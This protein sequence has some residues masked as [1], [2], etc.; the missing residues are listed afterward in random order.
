LKLGFLEPK[1]KSKASNTSQRKRYFSQ[2]QP[3]PSS[4]FSQ[5]VAEIQFLRD[6]LSVVAPNNVQPMQDIQLNDEQRIVAFAPPDVP[7]SIRAGAG[8]GKTHAMVQ[9]ARH[10]VT[11]CDIKPEEI[12]MITFSNKAAKEL[13]DRIASAF[14]NLGSSDNYLRQPTIKT[15]HGLAFAWVRM[16]WKACGLGKSLTIMDKKS[17]NKALMKRAISA[18]LDSLRLEK[19]KIMLWKSND[20]QSEE[21]TWNDVLDYVRLKYAKEYNEA[22]V[23]ADKEVEEKLPKKNKSGS[24]KSAALSHDENNEQALKSEMKAA[25]MLCMRKNCYLALL[26]LNKGKDATC[27]LER[28]WTGKSDQCTM[29]VNLIQQARLGG[30]S[31]DEYLEQDACVLKLYNQLQRETGQ[32]DFDNLLV[33][34]TEKVLGHETLSRRFN[35]M[36]SHVVVD[37]YQDNSDDQAKM[38]S[39]IVR[40]GSLTVVGDDDQ[41]SKSIISSL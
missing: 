41:C 32:L 1:A 19:C 14:S 3:D 22:C 34:F 8:S 33:V 24:K 15:F 28:R 10:L 26:R 40:N 2:E 16:H 18:Y 30:H 39:T 20:E 35:G 37:E 25:R 29:Y 12:L 31:F 5:R 13:E 38:L 7:L 6:T 17:Q 21:I 11:N 23:Q 4:A 36:Y 9:R 27:D